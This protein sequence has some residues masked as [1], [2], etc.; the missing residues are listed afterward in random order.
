MSTRVFDRMFKEATHRMIIATH[1]DTLNAF[2]HPK[3]NVAILCTRTDC[4]RCMDWKSLPQHANLED[5]LYRSC[6]V[7]CVSSAEWCCDTDT[8]TDVAIGYGVSTIPAVVVLRS[9]GHVASGKGEDRVLDPFD[10]L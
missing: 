2:R 7:S 9:E 10:F 3:G 8:A 5:F 4:T 6:G 1:P